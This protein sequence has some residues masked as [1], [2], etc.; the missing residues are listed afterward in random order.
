MEKLPVLFYFH[1]GGFCI[2]ILSGL[3]CCTPSLY[4]EGGISSVFHG[5]ISMCPPSTVN[6]STWA[7]DTNNQP[8]NI[9]CQN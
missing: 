6:P 3:L 4:A 8:G 1:G 5:R 2:A 9:E 7:A